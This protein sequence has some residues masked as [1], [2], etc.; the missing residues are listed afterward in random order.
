MSV[1]FVV[2]VCANIKIEYVCEQCKIIG[3][4]LVV[5]VNA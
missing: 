1:V 4:N 2:S 3:E 5:S